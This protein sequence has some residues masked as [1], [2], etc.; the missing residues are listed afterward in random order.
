MAFALAPIIHIES[1]SE[2]II[3]DNMT[4]FSADR[5][6][7]IQYYGKEKRVEVP[8]T[9]VKIADFAFACAYSIKELIIPDSVEEIG[10]CFLDEVL[11]DKILVPS[12]LKDL[13][14]QKT[15]S[16]YHKHIFVTE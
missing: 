2:D 7:L 16:L 12:K 3:V 14:E 10:N 13:V 9:V 5:K 8:N 11:P 6:E 15:E 1:H 4:I